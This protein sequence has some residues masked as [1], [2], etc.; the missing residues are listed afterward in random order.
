MAW[1]A[2]RSLCNHLS[3]TR[4]GRR[5]RQLR[6]VLRTRQVRVGRAPP[7]PPRLRLRPVRAGGPRALPRIRRAR[8]ALAH[9]VA[10]GWHRLLSWPCLL[11]ALCARPSSPGRSHRRSAP[12]RH[13]RRRR[14]GRGSASRGPRAAV[15]RGRRVA[16]DV[17]ERVLVVA[18]ARFARCEVVAVDALG[19][20]DR[21]V[22]VRVPKSG[23]K[24]MVA[25]L[26]S[27]W[28]FGGD[29]GVLKQ[30]FFVAVVGWRCSGGRSGGRQRR[31]GRAQAAALSGGRRRR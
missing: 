29:E 28:L 19:A 11:R 30:P 12:N 3:R 24:T 14:A 9:R 22:Y 27:G 17:E 15:L 2:R 5:H 25:L 13:P 7:L 31:Q 26:Q 23:S 20:R 10:C 4:I 8:A 6:A 18:L 1:L 16:E 21:L